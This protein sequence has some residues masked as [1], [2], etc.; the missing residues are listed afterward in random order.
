MGAP[1]QLYQVRQERLRHAFTKA[2]AEGT[3]NCSRNSPL[4][5]NSQIVVLD[6]QR[7]GNQ[8]PTILQIIRPKHDA[9]RTSDPFHL[10]A[11]AT[12]F[13][14]GGYIPRIDGRKR[15]F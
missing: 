1:T 12:L 15:T 2:L 3:K 9:A 5:T 11:P 14:D 7:T 8:I 4:E 6:D 10:D 13:V